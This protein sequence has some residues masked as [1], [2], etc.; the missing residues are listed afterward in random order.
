M[1]LLNTPTSFLDTYREPEPFL[2]GENVEK[3]ELYTMVY[4]MTGLGPHMIGACEYYMPHFINALMQLASFESS[5]RYLGDFIV[6]KAR[7]AG[8]I[9]LVSCSRFL[10]DG[11]L[12][13]RIESL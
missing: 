4:R 12:I 7:S 3:L 10:M 5:R 8:I 9:H 11:M 13:M 1:I 6:E 2:D